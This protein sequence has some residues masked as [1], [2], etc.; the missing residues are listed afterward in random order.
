MKTQNNII[1]SAA[2]LFLSTLLIPAQVAIGKGSVS[3]SSVSLEFAENENRGM[4]L[5]WVTSTGA[6][7]GVADGSFVYDLSDHKVKVKYSGGWKDL[8]VDTNGAT[9]T[10]EIQI[11]NDAT[12]NTNAKV[13]IGR[14]TSVPEANGILVLEDQTKAMILPKVASP[15]L[16]IINPAPGMMVYDTTAK[17]LAVFNGTVWSFWKPS[18]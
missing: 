12:E 4:I 8:S 18:S 3:N 9:G 1:I 6:V 17:Q 14:P 10:A 15:H 13:S 2:V 5:P 7:A 11:Q 16:N